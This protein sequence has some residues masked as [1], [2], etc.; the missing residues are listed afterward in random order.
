MAQTR[1]LLLSAPRTGSS[2]VQSGLS[3]LPFVMCFRA[4]FSEK[5][6]HK[7]GEVTG[8]L[9]DEHLLR[10]LPQWKEASSRFNKPSAFLNELYKTSRGF[11]HI[12]IK[13]H[14]TN[15]DIDVDVLIEQPGV[16][17]IVLSRE[18]ALASYSSKL[19]VQATGQ[20][21][22][23]ARN[24]AKGLTQ[25]AQS[26]V[27]FDADLFE[28][29]LQRRR[30]ARKRL[31]QRLR[32]SSFIEVDYVEARKEAGMRL[33][34][35]FLDIEATYRGFGTAKRHTDDIVGRFE[36]TGD[37]LSYIRKNRLEHWATER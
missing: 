35:G 16:K 37:V 31:I 13:H 28:T 9:R 33:I 32:A 18:N 6:W 21:A 30:S 14:Y 10:R 23:N 29:H 12:G 25:I 11:R 7:E 34:C 24:V 4:V 20:G 19:L 26:K 5:G 17:I 15:K 1:F 27:L 2:M 8:L 3:Q 36:N 22:A